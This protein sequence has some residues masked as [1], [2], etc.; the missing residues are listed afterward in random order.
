MDELG[1]ARSLLA[2]HAA[3]PALTSADRDPLVNT[4]DR[5]QARLEALVSS[6]KSTAVRD[7]THQRI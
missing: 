1:F 2:D 6:R 7:N 3:L 4:F 5:L